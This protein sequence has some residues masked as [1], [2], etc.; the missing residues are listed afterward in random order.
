[1]AI[2]KKDDQIEVRQCCIVIIIIIIIIIIY[3]KLAFKQYKDYDIQNYNFAL[4]LLRV[5][6]LVTDI[7]GGS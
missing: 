6:N 4:L 2:S 1:M 3:N 7:E 5:R